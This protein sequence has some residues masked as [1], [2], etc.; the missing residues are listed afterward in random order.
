[1]KTL[2]HQ[3][4]VQLLLQHD[5][6]TTES[7]ARLLAVSQ[8]T[9][10]RD[11][12]QLQKQGVLLRSHGR[13]RMLHHHGHS[14]DEPFSVRVK[15][16]HTHKMDIARLALGWI[17]EGMVI[18][19]DASTTCWH[20]ARLLPDIPVTVFTNSVRVCQEMAKR[21]QVRLFSSGGALDRVFASYENPALVSLLRHLDIDLFIFSC[22]G[23]DG[24]GGI[25]DAQG[26]N[27]EF[28]TLLLRRSAQSLLLIDKSKRERTG[29]VEI[30]T[31]AQVTEVI[32]DEAGALTGQ[33][34]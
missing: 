10:R 28:K 2:R 1:M 29:E 16:H 9:V 5:M 23:I 33:G 34:S 14:V 15:S 32:T 17:S 21:E 30:G 19:L 25:W 22:Q 12:S 24:Q 8:E 6:L 13:A 11:L 7:L 31:L 20:L 3:K 27:A 26:A 4:I 18:A